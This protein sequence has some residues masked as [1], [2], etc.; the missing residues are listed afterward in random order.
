MKQELER[1]R[2]GTDAVIA[3]LKASEGSWVHWR[4]FA[5]IAP[6]AWRTRLSDARKRLGPAFAVEWNKRVER[7]A[8]RLRPTPLGRD[9]GEPRAETLLDRMDGSVPEWRLR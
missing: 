3:L 2:F 5:A 4:R 8:Y 6:L 1:R 7:S 9:A